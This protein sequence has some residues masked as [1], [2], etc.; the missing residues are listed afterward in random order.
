MK[1]PLATECQ[2]SKGAVWTCAEAEQRL[3]VLTATTGQGNDGSVDRFLAS[4]LQL[5]EGVPDARIE[6]EHG[7]DRLFDQDR[8]PIAACDVQQF[9]AG[10]GALFMV[11]ERKNAGGQQD[12]RVT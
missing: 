7:P 3:H 5:R 6:P 12:V 1:V 8:Q 11:R 4:E 10:H 2:T 9:M